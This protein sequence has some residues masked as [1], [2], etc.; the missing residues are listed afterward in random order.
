MKETF[1]FRN[2][3]IKKGLLKKIGNFVEFVEAE[4]KQLK[5]EKGSVMAEIARMESRERH[6]GA[7][8]MPED[9]E[10]RV[11]HNVVRLQR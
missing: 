3:N 7:L 4:E 5:K 8:S 1:T 2:R 10:I 11:L 9:H 6:T